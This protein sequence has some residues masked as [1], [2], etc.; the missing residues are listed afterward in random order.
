MAIKTLSS[1]YLLHDAAHGLSREIMSTKSDSDQI[2]YRVEPEQVTP[3]PEP[4][5]AEILAKEKALSAVSLT[6]PTANVIPASSTTVPDQPVSAAEIILAIVAT[7]LRN[8]RK[9]WPSLGA[10][11]QTL[12]GGKPI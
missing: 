1:Q 12:C 11:I 9:T 6:P 4:L 8:E 5:Q 7:K 3:I 2:Y 10:T